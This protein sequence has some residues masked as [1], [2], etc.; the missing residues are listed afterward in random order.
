[1]YVSVW[2]RSDC[3]SIC[4]SVYCVGEE[5]RGSLVDGVFLWWCGG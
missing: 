2:C 3:V 4:E 5:G 1:M